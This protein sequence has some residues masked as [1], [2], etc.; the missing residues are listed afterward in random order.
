MKR[1]LFWLVLVIAALFSA[2]VSFVTLKSFDGVQPSTTDVSNVVSQGEEVSVLLTGVSTDNFLLLGYGGRGHDG[3][4]LSD[5]LMLVSVDKVNKQVTLTS[6]PRDLWVTIPVQSDK[7]QNYKINA[8]YAIGQDDRNYP[9]KEPQYKGNFGGGTL[10]KR[11][12]E[13]TLGLDIKNFAAV[14]FESFKNIID[15]LGGVDVDVPK[16]FD[17]YFYPVKGLENE[18]CGYSGEQIAEFHAKYS[19]FEL[20]KQFLCRYEH[21]HFEKGKTHMDGT[22]ALKFVR[23]RHSSEYGGDFARGERQNAVLFAAGDKFLSLY[24]AKNADAIYKEFKNLVVTDLDATAFKTLFGVFGD[25]G[26]Y[27]VK[28]VGLSVDNVLKASTS[29]NGQFILISKEGEGEWDGVREF[30]F[31]EISELQ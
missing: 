15:L 5:V 4:Y 31:Q 9:L 3:G 21:L 17:D 23:S 25:L 19:G 30:V 20:E 6:V 16:S 10:S 24:A 27:K 18:T 28:H 2:F 22:T 26:S 12:I 13:D 14:D 29:A 11:V 7:K 8:A 1:G